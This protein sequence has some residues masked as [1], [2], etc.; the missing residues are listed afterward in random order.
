MNTRVPWV[1]FTLYAA[2]IFFSCH[3]LLYVVSNEHN[4]QQLVYSITEGSVQRQVA[5]LAL[6]ALG[7]VDLLR[8][9]NKSLRIGGWLAVWLGFFA[10]W[11]CASLLWA[12]DPLLASKRVVTY[13]MLCMGGLGI[14]N[15]F[16]FRQIIQFLLFSTGV[17][18][19]LGFLIELAL[20][21][22][23]PLSAGYRFA[24]T[25]HPNNQ[26]IN[27]AIFLISC[28]SMAR[29]AEKRKKIYFAGAGLGFAF[30]A[31]TGSRTAFVSLLI[32]LLIFLY[33]ALP[34]STVLVLAC[35]LL[36][37]MAI[38]VLLGG[39]SLFPALGNVLLLGRADSSIYTLSARVPLWTRA[40]SFAATRPFLGFGFNSFWTPSHA[41]EFS[42]KEGWGISEAHSA[43]LDLVLG[44]GVIGLAGF[45]GI[46]G[47]GIRR[48]LSFLRRSASPEYAFVVT[49]LAFCILD[50]F[51]ESALINPTLSALACF[52]SIA[53]VGFHR[54]VIGGAGGE[55]A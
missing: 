15:R 19:A 21:K 42:M 30:L 41:L 26:A 43:Y 47:L 40:L 3:S 5:F 36:T 17:Y 44:V 46:L 8:L 37:I 38:L 12:D 32:S 9:R 35:S 27:C 55:W 4:A 20:G 29:L 48:A 18:I 31:L 14:V 53:K 10:I 2:A 52:I 54:P 11:I 45:L 28:L 6:G 50:G 49:L 51:L 22:F 39:N 24:G 13:T 23:N 1:G 7:L 16:S 34:K 25:M 33:I